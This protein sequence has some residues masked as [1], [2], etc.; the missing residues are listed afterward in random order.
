MQN[1]P[2]TRKVKEVESKTKKNP[3]IRSLN[4]EG[5]KEKN[6]KDKKYPRRIRRII[7]EREES[8]KN[9]QEE[10]NPRRIIQTNGKE[11]LKKISVKQEESKDNSG[12][13][14]QEVESNRKQRI[15]KKWKN[16]KKLTG[17]KFRKKMLNCRNRGRARF[18]AVLTKI[19]KICE[20]LLSLNTQTPAAH[21]KQKK[22]SQKQ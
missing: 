7:Q 16:K 21:I 2:R 15:Q 6:Q 19:L 22:R 12:R 18:Y 13:I 17:L 8:K 5:A 4:N 20:D 14:F 1:N 3:R 9:T 11:E 10:K